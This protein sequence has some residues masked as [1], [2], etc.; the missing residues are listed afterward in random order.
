MWVIFPDAR[1]LAVGLALAAL[2]AAYGCIEW[3]LR[4]IDSSYRGPLRQ[5]GLLLAALGPSLAIYA[6]DAPRQAL[7]ATVCAFI[8]AAALAFIRHPVW[9]Y[10]LALW[11]VVSYEL[12]VRTLIPDPRPEY[13]L[14]ALVVPACVALALAEVV[15]RHTLSTPTQGVFALE[16]VSR[17]LWAAPAVVVAAI[18]FAVSMLGSAYDPS[19]GSAVAA[20]YAVA[21]AAVAMRHGR[22]PGEQWVAVLLTAFAITNPYD[23][24]RANSAWMPLVVVG[25]GVAFAVLSVMTRRSQRPA[26]NAWRLP[27]ERTAVALAVVAAAVALTWIPRGSLHTTSATSALC[28]VLLLTVAYAQRARAWIYGGIA[29]LVVAGLIEIAA[30]RVSQTQ[31]YALPIG[32]YAALL[33]WVEWRTGDRS[34]LKSPFE[35]AALLVLIGTTTLQGMGFAHVGID[36]YAYD[37]TMIVEGLV[38]LGAGALLHWWRSLFAGAAAIVVAVLILLAEPLAAVN[39]WYLIGGLEARADQLGQAARRSPGRR[40]EVRRGGSQRPRPTHSRPLHC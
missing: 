1:V 23:R 31:A 6:V 29:A 4:G 15:A 16:A 5:A 33:A 7:V 12:A 2:G 14:S 11:S 35:I 17:T 25:A 10:P 21:L 32:F 26:L 20:I 39:A 38:V 22:L 28:G 8:F 13:V 19:V 9:S 37:V 27:L 40:G 18:A 3:Q 34:R 24:I 36:R 30:A